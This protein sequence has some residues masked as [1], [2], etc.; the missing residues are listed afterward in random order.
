VFKYI[1]P[2][3]QKPWKYLKTPFPRRRSIY[4]PFRRRRSAY[5]TLIMAPARPEKLE[6]YYIGLHRF[7]LQL[8]STPGHLEIIAMHWLWT[9]VLGLLRLVLIRSGFTGITDWRAIKFTPY[10]SPT[11]IDLLL[12]RVKKSVPPRCVYSTSVT[13]EGIIVGDTT[14]LLNFFA[15]VQMLNSKLRPIHIILQPTAVQMR[16]FSFIP[17][18]SIFHAAVQTSC[19]AFKSW[20]RYYSISAHE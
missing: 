15:Y 18:C 4:T 1:S 11:T 3:P 10:T 7:S 14:F 2:A 19:I 6:K 9:D 12:K 16:M 8:K 5:N 17:Y 20:S 13:N